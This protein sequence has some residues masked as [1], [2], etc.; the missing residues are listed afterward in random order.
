MK[1]TWIVLSILMVT[2]WACRKEVNEDD[3][4]GELKELIGQASDGTGL[5]YFTLPESDELALIPQD[6]LNP[7][8]EEKVMLG[9]LLFHETALGINPKLGMGE[10]TFSCASCHHADAGFQANVQQGI[11]EGGIGFGWAGED[12]RAN[13]MY[14]LDSIDV[15]PLRS[16]TAM[17]GAW[18]KNHLWNGQF[19][20]TD[21]N[22]GTES[23]WTVGTPI[24]TNNL[25]YEG[26][27]IQ[28]IAGLKVHRME[29]DTAE[30]FAMGYKDLFD[31]AF[32]N[33][34]EADR[35]D[36][37][38]AGLAIAAYERTILSNRA[39]FQ[40]YLKG[41]NLALTDD[42]KR[43]AILFFGEAGC[44]KCHTGPA[45][46]SMSFH[47]LG[48]NDMT[49]QVVVIQDYAAAEK[50]NRGR[51]GFTGNTDDDFKFK[52]PQLY[53]LN[54]STFY[55]HGGTFNSVYDVITYKNAAVPHNAI[56][57][58]SQLASEFQPLGLTSKEMRYIADFIQNGLYDD[59]LDRYTPGYVLSGHCIPN[60]DVVSQIDRGCN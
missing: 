38:R 45:L 18:Q 27:E 35:Y 36:R 53:N 28:A 58:V 7:L 40:D 51:G 44:V 60:D 41:S 26:L 56:V 37:E 10:G 54:N 48:M 9:K 59:Q 8:T 21:M 1:K 11:G 32:P 24:E 13:P 31:Y 19:G 23:Q 46:N 39:P 15:Q 20:A 33:V 55:G 12:R 2:V 50:A 25:G 47:A 43:G 52:V 30:L 6:P 17:N 49:D 22:I 5:A 57:P 34:P 42:E 29:I 3:L 16:P 4:D 14:P